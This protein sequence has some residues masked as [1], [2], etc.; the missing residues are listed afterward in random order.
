M[1]H[2]SIQSVEDIKKH[3]QPIYNVNHRHKEKLSTL[4]EIALWITVNVGSMGFFII[5]FLWTIIWLTW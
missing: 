2:Q 1:K 3:Y 4:D 5:I